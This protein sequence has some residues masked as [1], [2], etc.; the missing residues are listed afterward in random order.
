VIGDNSRGLFAALVA[1]VLALACGPVQAAPVR[2]LMRTEAGRIL[3]EV[4][5]DAAP[6]TA[7]NFLA[8]VDQGLLAGASFYRTVGPANDHNP[9][10]ITVLQGGRNDAPGGLPPIA[11]ETT[12]TTKLRHTDGVISMARD[13]PGTATSEFFI[14]IGPNPAL[15]FGGARN[16]DGQGFAAFGKVISGMR[17]VRKIAAA[18][19]RASADDPYLAGQLIAAPIR[20]LGAERRPPPP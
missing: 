5:P 7:G 12:A 4:Y 10:R 15:D 11:H 3:I 13:A 9:A 17:V 1:A 18:P 14:G 8:Y 6:V 16:A 19:T 20:I 2:V